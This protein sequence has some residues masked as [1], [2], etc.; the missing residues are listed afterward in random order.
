MKSM[1]T[2]AIRQKGNAGF[3]MLEM[4]ITVALVSLF[5]SA[6]AVVI[7]TI[8]NN[9]V[10]MNKTNKALEM[11]TVIENGIAAEW[12]KAY[13]I[14]FPVDTTKEPRLSYQVGN[15]KRYF[16]VEKDQDGTS[17]TTK[18]TDNTITVKGKP[19]IFGAVYDESFYKWGWTAEVILKKDGNDYSVK[20][21]IFDEN[22]EIIT[23]SEKPI[24][25]Y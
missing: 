12:A 3:T 22:D 9:Y 23:V 11:T 18:Y 19:I 10:T 15:Y 5:F 14:T 21:T 4:I 8:L 7:P 17:T 20:V 24:I 6:M 1:C 2:K 13:A 16:P 25:I